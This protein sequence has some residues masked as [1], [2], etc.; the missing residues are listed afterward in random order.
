[1][2]YYYFLN[3]HGNRTLSGMKSSIYDIPDYMYLNL[4]AKFYPYPYGVIEYEHLNTFYICNVYEYDLPKICG[5]RMKSR[6]AYDWTSLYL[7]HTVYL[8]IIL[9]VFLEKIFKATTTLRR[10]SH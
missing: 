9:W 8:I 5:P 7:Q 1:M 3:S 2:D 6:P 10:A 4:G